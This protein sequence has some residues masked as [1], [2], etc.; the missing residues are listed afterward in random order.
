MVFTETRRGY[1]LGFIY[2]LQKRRFFK[3]DN[4]SAASNYATQLQSLSFVKQEA[5]T[6]PMHRGVFG[7]IFQLLTKH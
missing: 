3:R 4:L 2:F 1:G 7:V 5:S 6:K